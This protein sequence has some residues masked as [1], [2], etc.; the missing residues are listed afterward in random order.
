MEEC[1]EYLRRDALYNRAISLNSLCKGIYTFTYNDQYNDI[2]KI[3]I[4]YIQRIN[5]PILIVGKINTL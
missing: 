1:S 4:Y 5:P 2:L 3:F